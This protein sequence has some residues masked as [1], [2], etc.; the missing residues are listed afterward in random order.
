MRLYEI[1]SQQE[2][3]EQVKK[4]AAWAIGNLEIETPPTIEYGNDL[5]KVKKHRTFG[6]TRSNGEIWVHLG[7]RN[8]ADICRTLCHELVHH[9]QFE[10][11]DAWDGMDDETTLKIEDEANAMAGRMMRAY[12]KKDERIYESSKSKKCNDD[13]KEL[14][15]KHKKTDYDSID[16]MM[17]SV[18]KEHK[19]TP[20]KL[21]DVWVDEYGVIPDTWIRKQLKS[22]KD[23]H[24]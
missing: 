2:K 24:D 8:V 16:K 17:K 9:R 20:K 19:I 13:L 1:K 14:L 23:S 15:L 21:H 4:F 11:G 6:S 7:N 18:A 3:V 5:G 10:R 22:K 12:G